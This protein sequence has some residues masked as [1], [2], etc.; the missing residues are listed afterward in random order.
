MLRSIAMTSVFT[1]Q[2]LPKSIIEKITGVT[3]REN[4]H[5]KLSQLSYLRI[6]YID[7]EGSVQTGEMI[8]NKKLSSEI[9]DIFREL[10]EAGYPIEKMRLADEYGGD[11]DKIMADNNT[12]CFNYRTV[13]GTD[14]V[15]LHGLGRAV[16][17][18]P[19]YNPYIV[20]GKIM[21]AK[22]A[23]Y[24]DR[25]RDFPYKIVKDDICWRIFTAHGWKWGGEW[26]NSK[27]YQHFYKPDSAML[28]TIRKIFRI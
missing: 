12:S 18:N 2:E 10:F 17:I 5:I 22:A 16:D 1:A 23:P 4:P 25:S 8:C 9:T 3:Y 26:K 20:G 7:F 24:A 14:T 13:A 6:S 28:R 27:D 19:L 11:D 21:P 15:S